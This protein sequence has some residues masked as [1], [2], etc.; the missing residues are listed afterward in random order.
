M[1]NLLRGRR[2]IPHPQ[3]RFR[4]QRN[5]RT[6]RMARGLLCPEIRREGSQLSGG[7]PAAN[8]SR[9]TCATSALLSLSKSISNRVNILGTGEVPSL[10]LSEAIEGVAD[11][12][13][14]PL[15][16]VLSMSVL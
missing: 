8:T 1:C 5:R 9:V 13:S 10:R 16:E 6:V 12:L 15:F 3:P 7:E 2:P 11:V 4:A 14:P